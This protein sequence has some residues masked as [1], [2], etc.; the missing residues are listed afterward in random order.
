MKKE[1]NVLNLFKTSLLVLFICLITACSIPYSQN[2]KSTSLTK[3]QQKNKCQEYSKIMNYALSYVE[4]E[5]QKGYFDFN[6]ITGAKAQLY[7][8]QNKS[9]SAFA[10]NI[11]KANTSYNVNYELAKQTKC[12]LHKFIISPIERVKV[13]IQVLENTQNNNKSKNV[14]S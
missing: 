4:E 10:Q 9:E 2:S 1:N 12:K 3:E 11:I 13:K 14:S 5:F 8:I 7:L 6:N